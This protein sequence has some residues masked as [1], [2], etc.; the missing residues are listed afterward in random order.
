MKKRSL[1]VIFGGM[2]PEYEVSLKSAYAVLSCGLD[3]YEITKIGITKDGNWY[4]FTGE[5]EEILNNSWHKGKNISPVSPCKG[6]FL[7]QGAERYVP[8]I[9]LPVAHGDFMEDGRLQ[10]VFEHFQ[11][12]Y[13]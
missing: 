6:G 8:D 13:V 12:P 9:V 7:I 2:S 4:H 3:E 10:A 5:N 1:C 11:I